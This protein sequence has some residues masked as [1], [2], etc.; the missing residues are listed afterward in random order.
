MT[1][2]SRLVKGFI[3]FLQPERKGPLARTGVRL[4]GHLRRPKRED[5]GRAKRDCVTRPSASHLRCVEPP[6][7]CLRRLDGAAVGRRRPRWGRP[8][9]GAPAPSVA[10]T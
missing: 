2:A 8:A 10:F 9:A 1:G 3:Y 6:L 7:A 4:G 5:E